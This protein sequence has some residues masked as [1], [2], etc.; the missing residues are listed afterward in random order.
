MYVSRA[1][2]LVVGNQLVYSSLGKIFPTCCIPQLPAVLCVELSLVGFSSFILVSLL[3]LSL[4]RSCLGSRIDEMLILI[5]N[6]LRANSRIFLPPHPKCSR[7]L[8]CRGVLQLYLLG[9]GSRAR[10]S[11]VEVFSQV[12]PDSY[13]LKWN[14][15]NFACFPLLVRGIC[16]EMSK[17]RPRL[18]L[19]SFHTL[20]SL[21]G[22]ERKTVM[23][24]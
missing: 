13:I 23:C 21:W 4:L 1:G 5:G 14:I 15:F 7:R 16:E 18:K 22:S 10:Q 6:S 11:F 2:H 9:L 20:L 12:N 19:R 3:L 8:R 17:R 24:S